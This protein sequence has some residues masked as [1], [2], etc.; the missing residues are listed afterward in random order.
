M[1]S[2]WEEMDR[3]VKKQR[4][5]EKQIKELQDSKATYGDAANDAD[6]QIDVWDVLK[7][8][9]GNGK[10]VFAPKSK[11]TSKKRK[12]QKKGKTSKKRRKTEDTDDEQSDFIDDESEESADESAQNSSG[13]ESETHEPLSEERITAK[14][15]D[16]RAAK[17]EAKNQRSEMTQEIKK[18]KLELEK[19]TEAE[20]EINREMSAKCIA[21]RNQY[22][23]GA[24]QL[25][26]AAG[27]KELDQEL[28]A[29]EDEGNFDPDAE[30]R[31]YDG[32][33]RALPV[34]C[35]SSRAYQKLQ[36][37]L[38]KDPHIAGFTTIEE[39]E[40]PQLQAHCEKLTENGRSANCRS[41]INKLNQLL[42]SLVLWAS[43]DGTGATTTPEQRARDDEFLQK[44]LKNLETVS[45][46]RP[47]SE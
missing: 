25:D 45:S 40:I 20:N 43:S 18:L 2:S 21:G 39:T 38:R 15:H 17:K 32:V 34:F 7:D 29:E 47:R 1:G 10:T 22:S 6:E 24:I 14:L 23:K 42:N 4:S 35:V 44:G 9:L 5:I 16:L 26:F 41:F 37:R 36:G 19:A 3:Q 31:D 12:T 27:I 11:L 33:A 28:A 30:A 13:D 46:R 8:E